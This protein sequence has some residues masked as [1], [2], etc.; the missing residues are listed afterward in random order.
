METRRLEKIVV[1]YIEDQQRNLF[2]KARF[3][4]A[5]LLATKSN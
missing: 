4:L 2:G 1:R 5:S 3:G